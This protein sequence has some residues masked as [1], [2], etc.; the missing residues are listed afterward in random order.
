[1]ETTTNKLPLILLHG[2][3]GSKAQLHDLA[4]ALSSSYDVHALN[5]PGHGGEVLTTDFSIPAFAAFVK[6]YIDT[7]KLTNVSIFGY[8][9]GGY[10]AVYL[11]LQH[12]DLFSKIITL[13]TKF[14]WDPATAAAESTMLDP[15][16]IEQKVPKFAGTLSERHAPGDWKQVLANTTGSLNSLGAAPL[17]TTANLSTIATPCLLLVGDRDKMISIEETANVYRL[18]PGAGFRV[19]PNTPHAIEQAPL[20]LLSH[21]IDSFLR[22]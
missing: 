12:P 11:S 19:L 16:K 22:P 5:L 6:D 7:H 2:A 20:A 14:I 21:L 4:T 10:V 3:I 18:I 1:M 8:S 9:M 17:L 13:A 15:I